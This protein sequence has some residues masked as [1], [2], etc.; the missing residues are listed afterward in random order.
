MRAQADFSLASDQKSVDIFVNILHRI[1]HIH[2]GQRVLSRAKIRKR[3]FELFK[4]G[5]VGA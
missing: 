1:V 5:N 2:P 4:D 3:A